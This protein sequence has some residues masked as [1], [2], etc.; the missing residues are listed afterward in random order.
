M[1]TTQIETEAPAALIRPPPSALRAESSFNPSQPQPE[2]TS[3]RVAGSCSPMPAV[4]TRPSS[5]EL[6]QMLAPIALYND[7]LLSQV[8][9][10][11]TYPLE[12]VEAAR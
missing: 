11:S 12:I 7:A 8:L 6:D 4:K 5:P 3:A 9:M 1:G 10:A 2:A